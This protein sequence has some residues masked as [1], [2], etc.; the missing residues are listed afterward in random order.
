[1]NTML[2]RIRRT[3]LFL[4]FALFP[5]SFM[6]MSPALAVGGTYEDVAASGL[7]CWGF[8]LVSSVV[9]SRSFCGYA[10]P[11]GGCQEALHAALGRPLRS[12]QWVRAIKD[13]IWAAWVGL[14]GVFAVTRGGWT[15][16]DIW[17][18]NPGFPPYDRPAY[19]AFL[20]FLLLP[21]FLGMALGRRAF[22]HYLCFFSPLNIIGA[23][24]ARRL[25]LP[26]LRIRVADGS[27]CTNCGGCA[28]ACPMTLDI[29]GMV[30]RGSLD[31]V[32]CITCGN[33]ASACHSGALRYGF[34]PGKEGP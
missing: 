21:V 11:L 5:I 24:V 26:A 1:M 33:C 28:A 7:L 31:D 13:A 2:Q 17:Y 20:V 16:I 18:Q 9:L 6:Y 23:V 32:E 3:L 8:V 4:A 15:R 25:S 10:C 19:V 12:M 14:I 30:A 22:C 34:T 27:Q 29:P